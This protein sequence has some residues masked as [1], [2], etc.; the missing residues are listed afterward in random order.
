MKG[1]PTKEACVRENDKW[2]NPGSVRVRTMY[3]SFAAM[4]DR[5]KEEKGGGTGLSHDY[6]SL[7]TTG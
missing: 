2:L 3:S 1:P 4:W 6:T 7:I 5:K